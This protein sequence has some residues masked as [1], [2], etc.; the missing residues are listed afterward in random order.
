MEYIK[1]TD[2]NLGLGGG[3]LLQVA[4]RSLQQMMSYVI[5]TPNGRTVV[6]D[7]GTEADGEHLLSLLSER[8]KCVDYWFI[9]HAH[10]DHLG[11][12]T[13]ILESEN[14]NL[15][16]KNLC[17]NFPDREW[18]ATKEDYE[19]NTRFLN[20]VA[21]HNIHTVK[22]CFGD[23]F[24]CGGINIEVIN[25]PIEYENFKAI[26]PTSIML[27]VKFPKHNVLFMGDFDVNGQ[28]GFLKYF[29]ASKLRC[30]IVQ[31]SHHGQQGV[32]RSFY[33]LIMP[34]HCLYTAPM[35]LWENNRYMCTNPETVGKGPFTI[36]E[37]RRWMDELGAVG[38]Y[39]I[40][41]GDYLFV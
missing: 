11:A 30:D 17:F 12:L 5:D 4:N 21:N 18:L 22:P 3:G 9:T 13:C 25:E 32:D 16:I 7:G 1:Q 38:S 36:M 2:V 24:E 8:G 29:D 40:A 14:F 27:L 23:V 33:E 34:K 41:D 31:M 15:D 10:S 19:I 26:N 35:W 20:A 28:E 39:P 6:I 37:T